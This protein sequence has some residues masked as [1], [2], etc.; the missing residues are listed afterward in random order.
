M[1]Q[2]TLKLSKN[3]DISKIDFKSLFTE[4]HEELGNIP[5]L[6]NRTCFSGIIHEDY[7]F[8]GLGDDFMTKVYLEVMW[9]ETPERI[10][11]KPALASRLMSIL[12]THLDEPIR[13]QSLICQPRVRIANLGI[14]DQEYH[15]YK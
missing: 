8:I 10:L 9:L 14:V 13:Q 2:I 3:I 15:I 12:L 7:S 11:L 6:D 4:I 1:P 5:K